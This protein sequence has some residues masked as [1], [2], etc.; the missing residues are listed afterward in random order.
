MIRILQVGSLNIGAQHVMSNNWLP[1]ARALL[2]VSH[3]CPLVSTAVCG[4]DDP[5]PLIPSIKALYDDPQVGDT[6]VKA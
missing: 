4:M 5:R 2:S 6:R 3:R 1:S